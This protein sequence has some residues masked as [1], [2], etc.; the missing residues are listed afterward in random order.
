MSFEDLNGYECRNANASES[1]GE[2]DSGGSENTVCLDEWVADLV[3]T[4]LT[5]LVRF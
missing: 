1:V 3:G 2:T 4:A 5:Y